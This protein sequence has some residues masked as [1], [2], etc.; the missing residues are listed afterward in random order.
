MARERFGHLDQAAVDRFGPLAAIGVQHAFDARLRHPR[1]F[2]HA[3]ATGERE[4]LEV[5]RR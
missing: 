1:H 5:A 4:R 2:H 3:I